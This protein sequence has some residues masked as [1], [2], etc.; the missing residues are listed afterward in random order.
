MW[1]LQ[2]FSLYQIADFD[3]AVEKL[4]GY[5]DLFSILNLIAD[6]VGYTRQADPDSGAILVAETL[7][8]V[9]FLE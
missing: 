8:Y 2:S 9:V 7:F 5:I 1:F 6:N 4:T 3:S